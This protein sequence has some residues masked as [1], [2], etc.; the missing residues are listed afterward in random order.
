MHMS[1]EPEIIDLADDSDEQEELHPLVTLPDE[2]HLPAVG[3]AAL[4]SRQGATRV[5][6]GDAA[7]TNT[8]SRSI[9]PT[10]AVSCA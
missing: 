9:V 4:D 3:N 2:N 5:C 10:H 1:K 8:N 7:G 6:G